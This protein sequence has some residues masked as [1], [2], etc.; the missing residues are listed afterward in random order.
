MA[1]GLI[2]LAWLKHLAKL[3]C[4]HDL[5]SIVDLGPQDVQIDRSQLDSGLRDLVPSTLRETLLDRIYVDGK[6]S[7]DCQ[8]DF[9]RLF[10]LGTYSSI[11]VDDKRA[12]Y[13][14]NLNE[15]ISGLPEF[16]VVT[17]FGTTEHVFNIGQAFKTVHE[18]TKPGGISLHCVPCFAFVNHGFYT[19]NPN[20]LVEFARANC[21]DIVD[22]SYYDNAF[23]R[24]AE[25]S[26]NGNFD[27]FRM[28]FL[29]IKLRDMEDSQT[30]M[31]KV[32][33]L[34]YRNLRARN[35]RKIL[36]ALNP[37][38][39][40]W[41][42]EQYPSRDFHICFVFDLIFF[43]MR[44]PQERLSFVMPIQNASGVPP[45]KSAIGTS[46]DETRLQEV[47][48]PKP[49]DVRSMVK[50]VIT[51]GAY[52]MLRRVREVIRRC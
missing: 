51:P 16:D 38:G 20:V 24:N 8:T 48:R 22:F 9:Y 34:Y 52:D 23:V 18:L 6:V 5:E 49:T 25:L 50:R 45:L 19:V 39:R 28:E 4:F 31:T 37:S 15:N 35:T 2:H 26:R 1:I 43:A 42:S 40:R 36:A 14:Q 47:D 11:D 7:P 29:P 27:K 17:N 21:Y 13:A 33:D 41:R 44:R 10:G 32:V 30:F 46:S 3:E 12:T